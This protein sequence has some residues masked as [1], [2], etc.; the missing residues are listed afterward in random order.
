[1][2]FARPLVEGRLIRRYKRFLAD[3]ALAGGETVTAHCANPGAMLG[4]ARPGSPVF[5]QP[6]LNPKRKLAWD[7]E[8][9][10]A[11][12]ADGPQYVGINTANPNRIAAEAISDSR[13]PAL[14]GYPTLRREVGF[15]ESSRVDLLL[16]GGGRPPCLVEVKNVHLL[17]RPGLA[18]FPDSVTER[19]AKHLAELS[20]EVAAGRRAVMLF[21]IQMRAASLAIA[22]DLDPGYARAFRDARAAGV[23]AIAVTCRVSPEEIAVDGE[24][25]VALS[26]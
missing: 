18:E 5:L 4:L 13:I 23:E 7:W 17:R 1:M 10:L 16:E 21:V 14:A 26:A 2:R 6:A 15:G 19:G 25:P 11:D 22:A 3:V 20:R 9:E 8:I 12:G 24:V